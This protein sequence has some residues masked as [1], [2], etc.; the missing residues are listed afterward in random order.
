MKAALLLVIF[1]FSVG[2]NA[3]NLRFSSNITLSKDAEGEHQFRKTT[4]SSLSVLGGHFFHY[5]SL[6]VGKTKY[7]A[8]VDAILG[9]S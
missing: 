4:A 1:L 8:D 7:S 3:L 9:G 6:S 5:T 2:I